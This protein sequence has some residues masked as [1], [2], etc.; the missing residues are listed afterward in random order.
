MSLLNLSFSCLI[1]AGVWDARGFYIRPGVAAPIPCRS[2][3]LTISEPIVRYSIVC[4]ERL[5]ESCKDFVNWIKA[6]PLREGDIAGQCCSKPFCWYK[7]LIH[8]MPF[9]K[10]C[11]EILFY[12]INAGTFLL[13]NGQPNKAGFFKNRVQKC[14]QRWTQ[15]VTALCRRTSLSCN[16]IWL[17]L[18]AVRLIDKWEVHVPNLDSYF[19]WIWP[20][21]SKTQL[22]MEG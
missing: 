18:L 6:V 17:A 22:R 13:L 16:S 9:S 10:I 15:L 5:I 2:L 8:V 3:W 11:A 4:S 1:I 19:K 21:G 14:F 7:L 20:D 12:M